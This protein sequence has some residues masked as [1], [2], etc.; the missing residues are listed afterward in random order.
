MPTVIA[1]SYCPASLGAK[2]RDPNRPPSSPRWEEE[3]YQWQFAEKHGSTVAAKHQH[4]DSASKPQCLYPH[5]D[6]RKRTGGGPQK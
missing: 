4:H 1:Q 2:P 5:R 6:A 3:P